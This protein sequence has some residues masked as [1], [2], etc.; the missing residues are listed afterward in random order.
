VLT[1]LITSTTGRGAQQHA[2]E[3]I[4][5]LLRAARPKPKAA[6]GRNSRERRVIAR[7]LTTEQYLASKG[8][9]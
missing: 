3:I 8:K 1:K 2:D 5:K 4:A 6:F 9:W 7:S